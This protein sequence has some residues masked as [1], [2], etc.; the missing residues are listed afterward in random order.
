MR[1]YGLN[2]HGNDNLIN[3]YSKNNMIE[4]VYFSGEWCRPCQLMKPVLK[5]LTNEN[6]DILIQNID[7]DQNPNLAKQ[8]DVRSIPTIIFYKDGVVRDKQIGAA[9]KS[10][11]QDKINK[12]K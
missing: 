10:I 1:I 7:V 2:F 5:E 6:L 9:S 8:N 11:L 3:I 4:L 12:L